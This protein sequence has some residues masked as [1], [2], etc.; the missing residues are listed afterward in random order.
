MAK[1]ERWM[2]E[3]LRKAAYGNPR[4]TAEAQ[5][6]IAAAIESALEAEPVG[7]VP[8][9][10]GWLTQWFN[11]VNDCW[12]DYEI[13][14]EEPRAEDFGNP[15]VFRWFPLYLHPPQDR[16]AIFAP[17]K[18]EVAKMQRDHRAMERLRADRATGKWP[19]LRWYGVGMNTK[20]GWSYNQVGTTHDDPADAILGK[21]E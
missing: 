8:G 3:Y 13:T 1:L 5:K 6:L 16:A 9:P 19:Q 4:F 7:E 12:T 18:D 21:G 15:D 2:V 11:H 17:T 20:E 14:M 10:A